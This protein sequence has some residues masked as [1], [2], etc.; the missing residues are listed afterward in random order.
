MTIE[1]IYITYL[2]SNPNTI[3]TIEDWKEWFENRFNEKLI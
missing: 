1:E 2:K 3:I